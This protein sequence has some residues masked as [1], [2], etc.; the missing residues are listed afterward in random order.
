MNKTRFPY[1]SLL[2]ACNMST[3]MTLI[4][5]VLFCVSPHQMLA[6]ESSSAKPSEDDWEEMFDG[7]SLDGWKV[8]ENPDS[9]YL[10]D[11]LFVAHGKRGHA[12]YVGK[13]GKADFTDFHFKTKVKTTKG[14]NSGIYFHTVYQESGWPN[15]GYE[16]QVNNTQKDKRKTGGLYR[17]Q[18]NFESPVKDDQWFDYDVIVKGKR[19]VLKI[20]GKTISDYTEPDDLDRPERCLDHGTIAIQ[21][22]DPGSKVFY[23]DMKVKRLGPDDNP[24]NKKDAGKTDKT[25]THSFIGFGRA[26]G[27]VMIDE[28][29]ET[30]WNIRQPASDGCLLDNGNLL[31]AL[32]PTKIFP[33]GAV[34]EFDIQSKEILWSYSGQQKEISTVTPLD[35]QQFLV[36]EL[37]PNPRAIVINRASEILKQMPLACQKKNAHMQTRML[38]PLD[39][40]N[41]IAPHLLDFAVKEYQPD[42][43]KVVSEF[44][45]DDRGQKKHDWPFTAIRMENGN[46][47][48]GCTHGNRVI[49]VDAAGKIVWELTNDDL[50]EPLINDACGIQLLPSGNVIVSSYAAKGD[51]V[52]LFEVTREKQV[53]WT[54]SGMKHGFHHVQVLSTDGQPIANRM[55]R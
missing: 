21:A 19:I 44:K 12:F 3:I 55:M 47:L 11:G 10:E 14:S 45:T 41:W 39:N 51:R 30:E 20:N 34:A 28:N 13:D 50:D 2:Q 43:G 33:K 23:K 31:V 18:D 49:E 6:Q 36:A 25:T 48:I 16:A 37:G 4:A 24:F 17:I 46:T 52:K 5:V 38:R 22:H 7:K 35:D 40:G 26:N 54:Y 1:F 27:I 29:G 15:K 9:V 32:Y 42:S 53:V 8:S